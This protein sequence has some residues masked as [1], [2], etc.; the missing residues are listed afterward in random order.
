[1]ARRRPDPRE[2]GARGSDART[3]ADINR[4]VANF[5]R[6]PDARRRFRGFMAHMQRMPSSPRFREMIGSVDFWALLREAEVVVGRDAYDPEAWAVFFAPP[7]LLACLD[8]GVPVAVTATEFP[9]DFAA[10]DDQALAACCI[11]LKGSSCYDYAVCGGCAAQGLGPCGHDRGP[12]P[13]TN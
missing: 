7:A 5:D 12:A 1:M 4:A 10:G 13:S 6:D 2:R 3:R 8:H 9:L 11:V